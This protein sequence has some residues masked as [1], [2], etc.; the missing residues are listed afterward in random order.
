METCIFKFFE[1]PKGVKPFNKCLS[2]FFLLLNLQLN[3]NHATHDIR[4]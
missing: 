2:K 1:T 3:T 4:K